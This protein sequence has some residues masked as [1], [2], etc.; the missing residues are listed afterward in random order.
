MVKAANKGWKCTIVKRTYFVKQRLQG[1]KIGV[2]AGNK[3]KG[4]KM[5]QLGYHPIL[6]LLLAMVNSIKLPPHYQIVPMTLGYLPGAVRKE[7]K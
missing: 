2:W 6:M 3:R 4:E 5:Y 1:A 7:K